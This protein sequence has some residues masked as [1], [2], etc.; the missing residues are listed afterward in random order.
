MF[1]SNEYRQGI[2]IQITPDHKSIYIEISWKAKESQFFFF[3]RLDGMSLN[4]L[5]MLLDSI[6]DGD[7]NTQRGLLVLY[8]PL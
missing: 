7:I 4:I 5:A 2:E 8:K 1:H 3:L 6:Y